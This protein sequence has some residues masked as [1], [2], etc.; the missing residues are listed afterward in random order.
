M[1]RLSFLLLM[2][3]LASCVAAVQTQPPPAIH[4]ASPVAEEAPAG[5]SLGATETRERLRGDEPTTPQGDHKGA[6]L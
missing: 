5:E 6:T 4:P 1:I 2:L 3:P